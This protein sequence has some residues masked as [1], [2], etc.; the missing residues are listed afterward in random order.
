MNL[1]EAIETALHT[2]DSIYF[3]P[4]AMRGSGAAYCIKGGD[5]YMVP[6]L[7]GG[8]LGITSVASYLA[9]EWEHV[10]MNTVLA[11]HEAIMEQ[12]K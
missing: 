12:L 11:E 8:S 5:V 2:P 9:G 3:R 10:S 4:V 7:R 1:S 6:T